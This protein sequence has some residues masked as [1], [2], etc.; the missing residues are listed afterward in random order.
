MAIVDRPVFSQAEA[1][2]MARGRFDEMALAYIS[3]EGLCVGRTDLRAGTVISMLG[4]GQRF[5]GLYYL[6]S[7]THS[8]SPSRGYI[9]A[10]SVRRNAA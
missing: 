10:F 9:T 2:G 7:V 6:T 8:Y 1:D 4:L 5:S 3:G